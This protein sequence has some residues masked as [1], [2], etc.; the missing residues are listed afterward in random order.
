[1]SP[2]GA[3]P[4]AATATADAS[5]TGGGGA[6][7]TAVANAGIVSNPANASSSAETEHGAMAQALS[8]ISSLSFEQL[9]GTAKAAAKTSFGGVSVQSNA[10]DIFGIF[11][12]A[13]AIAQGGAAQT[14][15]DP[16][17]FSPPSRSPFPTRPSTTLIDGANNVAEALLGPGDE[18]FGASVLESGSSTFDFRFQGHLLLGAIDGFADITV[19]GAQIFSGDAGDDT[20]INLGFFGPHIELTITDGFGTFFIGGAVPEP[21]TWAMLLLG[22]AGL[23]LASC[24][25]TRGA[26]P[27]PA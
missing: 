23:G 21:S 2:V 11:G 3:N 12:A 16:N 15:V 22:F 6:F 24:R 5:A 13:D 17:S 7:A 18:I 25:Q 27:Q 9:T 4:V 14:F 26:K 8:T 19:N 1:M 10:E 20:V